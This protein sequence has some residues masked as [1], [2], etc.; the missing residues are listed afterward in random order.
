MGCYGVITRNMTCVVLWCNY[1]EHNVGV[2]VKEHDVWCYGV[3]TWNI[4]W[5]LWCNYKEHDMWGVMV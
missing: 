4:T 2:M 3:I 5:V 1:M